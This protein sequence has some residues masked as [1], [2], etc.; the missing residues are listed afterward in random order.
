MDG[1]RR[2]V[3]LPVV[4]FVLV[5]L[6][7][8]V[9]MF[10]FRVNAD[11]A[12]TQAVAYRQQARLAAEA[13]VDAVKLLLR[14]ARLEV[15]RW[16]HNPDELHRIIVWAPGIEPTLWGTNEE[17][18]EGWVAF[19]FSIVA[20]DPTDDEKY[21]RFGITDAAACVNLNTATEEQLLYLVGAVAGGDEEFNPT[22][23]VD[24]ILDW[25]DQ[26]A[27]PRGGAADTEGEYYRAL[28]EPYRVKNGDF[29]TVEE[30]L[31]VKGVT[32]R[33]LFG[34]D[35][36][37][38]G[39]LSPNEDDGDESFPPDN[40][41]GVLNRGVFPYL[42]VFSA[43]DNVSNDNRQ[44]IYLFA[45]ENVVREELGKVF[46]D[47]PGVIDY[48]VEVTRTQTRGSGRG[49]SPENDGGDSQP[50]GEEGDASADTDADPEGDKDATRQQRR[51][52][53]PKPEG[54]AAEDADAPATG[55][56]ED[57]EESPEAETDA[58]E[59]ETDAPEEEEESDD[60]ESG[61]APIRSPASLLIPRSIR[62]EV[63]EGPLGPEHLAVL[64]DRT[65]TVS[66][67]QR[68][69]RGLI[70]VNTAP[71]LVLK[72]LGELTD[73]QITSIVD[74]RTA[75]DAQTKAT[76]AWLVTEEVVDLETFERIAPLITARGQQ[77]TIESLGYADHIGMVVR[78]QVVVDMVGPIAQTVYYRDLTHL[79]GQ[80]PIRE[81]DK[82][83]VRVR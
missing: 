76:P 81:E 67:E 38:N 27:L 48:I 2:G 56:T 4:L 16:Y 17:L 31:L 19:R 36:D 23:I 3:I 50:S 51:D 83:N 42:T 68:K 26:D 22:E 8:L 34:E 25:R 55:E 79:G 62:G 64:M 44:R 11:L 20:D 32:P 5:L 35:L 46:E 58:P 65:T 73:E 14:T 33:I 82:D 80:Y 57:E 37:R 53:D 40:G 28:A 41:D 71:P 59:E 15:N 54:D 78:L 18:D 9:A 63:R 13:G 69:I 72:C 7:L 24:A 10:S 74:L 70:N 12:A 6:G 75:L 45:D 66:S 30:L 77:F 1:T 61:A 21:I 60:V 39:L 47:D 29:D 52:E 43:E 49:G